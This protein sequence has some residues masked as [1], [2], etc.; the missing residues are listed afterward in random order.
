MAAL[1]MGT[2]H[3]PAHAAPM[4]SGEA[5]EIQVDDWLAW[6]P[7]DATISDVEKIL[8]GRGLT[9][10]P[11]AR[12]CGGHTIAQAIRGRYL[13]R[14]NLALGRIEDPLAAI[15]YLR[16]GARHRT[17]STP[18][19]A[20]G[21]ELR[22]RLFAASEVWTAVQLRLLRQEQEHWLKFEAPTAEV[23]QGFVRA[24]CIAGGF[25]RAIICE[26]ANGWL[27]FS[28]AMVKTYLAIAKQTASKYSVS[29]SDSQEPTARFPSSDVPL[30]MSSWGRL[31]RT[32]TFYLADPW[33][34]LAKADVAGAAHE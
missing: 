26:G 31:P 11:V 3:A 2:T 18:R 33:A 1:N 16:D 32:A 21:P 27:G 8:Q 23:A 28:G 13:V 25:T 4:S 29:T 7:A 12:L 34:V 24:V 10:G 6:V 14:S 30:V 9:I 17:L 15:E 20:C 5:F 22:Q 19:E